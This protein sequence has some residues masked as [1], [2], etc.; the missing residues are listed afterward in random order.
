MLTALQDQSIG[1]GINSIN[2]YPYFFRSQYNL[3]DI[4]K[5]IKRE[6]DIFLDFI[7]SPDSTYLNSALEKGGV[8]S[9]G[10]CRVDPPHGWKCF[11]DMTNNHIPSVVDKDLGYV[12]T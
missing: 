8:S 5:D 7:E 11:D 6:T 1:N 3:S 2:P 9:V 4:W 10:R 12:V